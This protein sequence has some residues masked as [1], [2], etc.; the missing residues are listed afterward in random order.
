M[1]SLF[2]IAAAFIE[3]ERLVLEGSVKPYNSSSSSWKIHS[4][5]TPVR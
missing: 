4:K 1:F 2:A 5:P 3:P